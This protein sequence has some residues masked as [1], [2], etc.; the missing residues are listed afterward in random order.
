MSRPPRVTALI[1]NY[2]YGRYLPDA[3]ESALAQD[4]AE[5]FEVV[6]VDDGS[7]DDSEARIKPY[8]DR[9]RWLRIPHG[10][11]AAAFN[12]GLAEA[13]GELVAMLDSDDWW[14]KDKLR[15]VVARFD[16]DPSLGMVQHFTVEVDAAGQPLPIGLPTVPPTYTLDDYLT[17]RTYFTGTTGLSFRKSRVE[18][19]LP[20][21]EELTYCADEYLFTHILFYGPAGNIPE[22]LAR[23][24]IHGANLYGQTLH[25][26][27]R[28]ARNLEI[29]KPIEH[30]LA[31]R[32]LAHGKAFS[33]EIARLHEIER[34]Q[35]LTLHHRYAG[36]FG[37]AFGA[38][39]RLARLGGAFCVFKAAALLP[40]IV[41][42]RLFLRIQSWYSSSGSLLKLR[43][44][45]APAKDE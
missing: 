35:K 16:A 6:V 38:I 27:A 20:V 1:N 17:R 30:H 40:A 39:G 10:G 21:P 34:L 9:V 31:E 12:A 19:I 28:L 37:D 33:P 22:P 15:K 44:A 2:N 8:L 41:S 43:R 4:L 24:R 11:Q 23:R 42:P 5:P 13:R 29:R 18:K 26:P 45:V 36:R 14:T 7:T 25:D 3:V 32:L